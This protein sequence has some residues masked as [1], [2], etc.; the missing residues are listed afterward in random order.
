MAYGTDEILQSMRRFAGAGPES[1]ARLRVDGGAS[2]NGWLMQF[3]ADVLGIPVERPDFV[4]ITALGAAALAGI[5]IGLWTDGG[6]V[7]AQRLTTRF[8]P[9]PGR[10]AARAGAGEWGRAVDATLHWAR[11]RPT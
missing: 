5:G 10:E 8:A 7:A 4:E 6:A 2:Q 1:F 11:S 9:G 3:Q